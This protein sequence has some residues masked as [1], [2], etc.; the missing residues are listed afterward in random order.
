MH[1][2][3]H[4]H[5]PV[6]VYMPKNGAEPLSGISIRGIQRLQYRVGGLCS[7]RQIAGHCGAETAKKQYERS[8]RRK[9][10]T[11]KLCCV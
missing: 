8:L 11:F 6:L 3:I 5:R 2:Q 1:R 9:A 7:A 4:V 10:N